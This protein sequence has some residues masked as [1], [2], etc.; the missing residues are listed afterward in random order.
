MRRGGLGR[1]AGH[2][3]GWEW[4]GRA[5]AGR[6]RPHPAPR[7]TTLAP[8]TNTQVCDARV[9]WPARQHGPD[10]VHAWQD[11][12]GQ[13]PAAH[14]GA[15][16]LLP[17]PLLA[18]LSQPRPHAPLHA[19]PAGE[20]YVAVP[21]IQCVNKVIP[22]TNNPSDNNPVFYSRLF[23]VIINMLCLLLRTQQNVSCENRINRF[24]SFKTKH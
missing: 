5:D 10:D 20:Y 21:V 11:D 17:W 18:H 24:Y 13:E 15:G 14:L 4:W 1:G 8:H 19:Q 12:V 16:A 23:H 3:C 22:S 7:A 2:G 6:R 9:R